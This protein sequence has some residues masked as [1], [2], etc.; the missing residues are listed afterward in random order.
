MYILFWY[1]LS[2]SICEAL[3]VVIRADVWYIPLKRMVSSALSSS[4]VMAAALCTPW[5]YFLD[6]LMVGVV[7]LHVIP[8]S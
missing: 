8:G 7:F 2:K 1:L 3:Q 4:M 5:M 6:P